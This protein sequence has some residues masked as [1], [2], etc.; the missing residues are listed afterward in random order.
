MR[1]STAEYYRRSIELY[2]NLRIGD[3]K[4]NKLTGRDLQKLY[5]DLRENGRLQEVQKLISPGLSASTVR[6]ITSRS[7]TR[8]TGQ[9]K[10]ASYSATP[11]MTVSLQSLRKKK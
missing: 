5:Q 7:T 4:L 6:G 3:I 2:V 8:W 1:V 10:N 11:P 9:S